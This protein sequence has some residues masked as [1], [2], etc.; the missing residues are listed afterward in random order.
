MFYSEN[1]RI[2][3]NALAGD[4]HMSMGW[5]YSLGRGLCALWACPTM[6]SLWQPQRQQITR[7]QSFAGWRPRCRRAGRSAV[8]CCYKSHSWWQQLTSRRIWHHAERRTIMVT[9]KPRTWK[10]PV[11]WTQ[12]VVIKVLKDYLNLIAVCRVNVNHIPPVLNRNFIPKRK[13]RH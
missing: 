2:L 9:Q 8:C 13:M 10:T 5:R 1:V 11:P 4:W 6:M 3:P 12:K 7:C